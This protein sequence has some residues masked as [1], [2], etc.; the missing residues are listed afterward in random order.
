MLYTNIFLFHQLCAFAGTC[1]LAA[2]RHETEITSLNK[3]AESY[4][5]AKWQLN[6]Y[7]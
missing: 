1:N 7:P 4:I 5:R 2:C 6:S 3:N